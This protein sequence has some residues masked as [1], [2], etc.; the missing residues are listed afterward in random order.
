[1]KV[2]PPEA[3][4]KP[5]RDLSMYPPNIHARLALWD[6]QGV[7]ARILETCEAHRASIEEVLAPGR[8][9]D[10]VAHARAAC[11]ASLR[12]ITRGGKPV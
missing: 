12:R 5:A 6:R 9:T 2:D 1:M 8:G 3:V 7:L 11:W 4:D 10:R